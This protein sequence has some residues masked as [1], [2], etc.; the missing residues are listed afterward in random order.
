MLYLLV[1]VGYIIL[2]GNNVGV[3]QKFLDLLS[4]SFSLKD[5][6]T[7]SYFLELKLLHILRVFFYVNTDTSL[8]SSPEPI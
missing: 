7:L 2:T 3:V 8:I 6:G 5:L 1:H 4:Q